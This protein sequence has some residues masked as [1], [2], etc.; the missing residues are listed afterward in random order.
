MVPAKTV[1]SQTGLLVNDMDYWTN[2][3]PIELG[4]GSTIVRAHEGYRYRVSLYKGAY[5]E[6]LVKTYAYDVE[7][8]WTTFCAQVPEEGWQTGSY[9]F[10]QPCFARIT[11]QRIDGFQAVRELRLDEVVDLQVVQPQEPSQPAWA[12]AE[13]ERVANRVAELREP[14]DLVLVELSG[15][16]YSTGCIWP[17]TARNVRAVCKRIKPAAIV[18]LGDV[19]DGLTPASVM[20]SFAQRVLGD[21]DGCGVPV[22]SCIG[23]H[24]VNR[25]RGN[26]QQLSKQEC[27]QL[28]V[29]RAIPWYYQDFSH[30]R[31]RCVFL[32][33]F[34]PARKQRY[35]FSERQVW[36]LRRVLH[37]TPRDWKVLVFSH[38]PPLAE[39]HYWSDVIFNGPRMMGIL[40]RFDKRRPGSVLGFVHG[41]SHVDQVYWK[42]S[43]PNVSMGCAKLEDFEERKPEGSFTPARQLG[44]ASQ[45]LWNVLVVKP[46]ENRLC[47]VRF[48]AGDDDEVITYDPR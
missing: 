14:G 7:S 6:S 3:E 29:G 40:E 35:G 18:Q 37:K 10:E 23:N 24:D 39:I 38:V 9:T 46:R 25:F 31:V 21:L 15:I 43:F 20:R 2:W 1:D 13:I 4:A 44:T 48:G 17:Q 12:Q 41:H 32:D 42:Q 34:D 16:H 11:V 26:T 28:Y 30:A 33:S 8:N 27:S 47:W 45:D 5:D 22:F 19:S 36:W